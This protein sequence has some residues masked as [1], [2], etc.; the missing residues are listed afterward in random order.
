MLMQYW[1]A[2]R[3]N[4]EHLGTAF[5]YVTMQPLYP[6]V[7]LH[8]CPDN[9]ATEPNTVLLWPLPADTNLKQLMMSQMFTVSV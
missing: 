4:G 8:R 6:T 3:K 9:S 2:C 1:S 7:G 5:I